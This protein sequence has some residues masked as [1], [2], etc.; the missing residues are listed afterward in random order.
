MAGRLRIRRP[1][2]T[3]PQ[4]RR[5]DTIV[6]H[7]KCSGRAIV[8][9]KTEEI[10]RAVSPALPRVEQARVLI[11]DD[12]A[13]VRE[14]LRLLL[15]A[16]G[17][18]TEAVSSPIAALEA[19]QSNEFD[20]MLMDLNYQRDTTSGQEGIDLLSRLQSADSKLPVIVMTAW[21]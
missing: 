20:V 5:L 21:G 15:K 11:A 8:A 6:R 13:D 16:E 4:P 17:Y 2:R 12:Q 10:G 19:V 18:V 7:Y 3:A 9:I 14:A 1:R